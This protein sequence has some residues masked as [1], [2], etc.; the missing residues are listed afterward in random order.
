MGLGR[1]A[2]VALL[3]AALQVQAV[4]AAG[5]ALRR[6]SAAHRTPR[7]SRLLAEAIAICC[8]LWGQCALR[9][10]L[11][12]LPSAVSRQHSTAVT[13]PVA[14]AWCH[15]Y[16]LKVW[17][18]LLQSVSRDCGKTIVPSNVAQSDA[19]SRCSGGLAL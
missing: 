7:R 14:P 19:A 10:A 16:E 9:G 3:D 15:C 11:K 2:R 12:G 1:F 17:M 6:A 4:R 5:G 8:V 13:L 18:L